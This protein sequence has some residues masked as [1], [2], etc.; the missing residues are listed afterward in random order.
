MASLIGKNSERTAH[1][2]MRS[3]TIKSKKGDVAEIMTCVMLR[4]NVQFMRGRFL[5]VMSMCKEEIN[6][7]EKRAKNARNLK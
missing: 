2:D 6:E 5:V 3:E 1:G 7:K 4:V